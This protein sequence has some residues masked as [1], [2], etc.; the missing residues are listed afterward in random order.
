MRIAFFGLAF[1]FDFYHIGGTESLTRRIAL[2]LAELGE[3]VEFVY[4]GAPEDKSEQPR[5]GIV[6]LYFRCLD[7]ALAHIARVD[8][9]HVISIYLLPRDRL[10]YAQFRRRR[11]STIRFHHIYLGWNESR[12]RRTIYF[13]E[14][15]LLPFNGTLFCVSPRI[16]RYVSQWARH[17]VLFLPPVSESYFCVPEGKSN[18]NKLRLAYAGRIDPCKG[19][20]RVV[21]VFEYL[22]SQQDIEARLF[23]FAWSHRRE[24]I[25]LHERLLA[26]P[27]I[28]YEP[29]EY[30]SWSP[31]VDENL[32]QFLKETD[33]LVL[34]YEKL[35]STVDTPLLLLE[36]MANLCAVV[37]PSLGELHDIYGE[38]IF[39]LVG[40]WSTE[41]AAK[42]I[43]RGRPQLVSERKRLKARTKELGFDI[44]QA[45]ERFRRSLVG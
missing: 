23:G 12:I 45:T 8:C 37:T 29:V 21:E 6:L 9:D 30:K 38:S 11:G 31:E 17:A 43:E 26:N 24:T 41:A 39:N 16:H 32:C 42:I 4:Y 15:Q 35:S 27:D 5:D 13:A 19:T 28:R 25:M 36:G 22:K 14:A 20:D 10:T 40:D 44:R 33:I 34:P 1:S 2:R 18:Y 7:D 3:Q